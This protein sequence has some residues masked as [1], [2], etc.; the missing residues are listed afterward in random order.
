MLQKARH[1]KGYTLESCY[2]E[3]GQVTGFHCDNQ[4]WTVCYLVADM[5]HWFKDRQI[6]IPPS[7]I[8]GVN[9]KMQTIEI[10]LS[11]QQI[12]DIP[13]LPDSTANTRQDGH[14]GDPHMRSCQNLINSP[15][16][17]TDGDLGYIDDFLIDIKTWAIPYFIIDVRK[18]R[19]GKKVMFSSLWIENVNWLKAKV[20]VNLPRETM[21]Q[22]SQYTV[23]QPLTTEYQSNLHQR[24]EDWIKPMSRILS[25]SES[26]ELKTFQ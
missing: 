7:A 26:R 6:L 18:N 22:T 4:H 16:R 10:S 25:R 11:K 8:T 20:Y 15:V 14:A 13:A 19:L 9:T 23:L 12:D 17:G 5:G 1:L 21:K 24:W 3:I 2:G